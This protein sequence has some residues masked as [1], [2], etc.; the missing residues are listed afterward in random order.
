MAS[1]TMTLEVQEDVTEG[2]FKGIPKGLH[3]VT[4]PLQ[5]LTFIDTTGG[6][7]TLGGPF[8]KE[9]ETQIIGNGSFLGSCTITNITIIGD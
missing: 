9:N 8:T 1:V 7:C 3:K 5:K 2:L 4:I 6:V